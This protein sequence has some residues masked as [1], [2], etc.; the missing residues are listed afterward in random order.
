MSMRYG[1]IG[2]PQESE[3]Q[4]LARIA[5]YHRQRPLVSMTQ[6]VKLFRCGRDQAKAGI[7]QA[8]EIAV[9]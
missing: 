3:G 4:L 8:K 9:A 6:L 2:Q 7:R 1:T 5:D